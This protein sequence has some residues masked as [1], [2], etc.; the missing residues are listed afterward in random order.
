M[1]LEYSN[2]CGWRL[3]QRHKDRQRDQAVGETEC[4]L[5]MEVLHFGVPT[6]VCNH[7]LLFLWEIPLLFR[8]HFG[9]VSRSPARVDEN[10]TFGDIRL[11]VKLLSNVG[12]CFRGRGSEGSFFAVAVAHRT[13]VSPHERCV[14]RLH[15]PGRHLNRGVKMQVRSVLKGRG[16][17]NRVEQ[18]RRLGVSRLQL[19]TFGGCR[20]REDGRV[21]MQCCACTRRKKLSFCCFR[22]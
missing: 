8:S 16:D 1:A 11:R 19:V 3:Q 2:T 21:Q 14:C 4:C 13:Q 5:Y 7:L 12:G 15:L 10:V 20:N 22:P 6:S 17:Q 9:S 18:V